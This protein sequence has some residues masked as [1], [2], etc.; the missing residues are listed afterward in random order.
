MPHIIPGTTTTPVR[1]GRTTRRYRDAR[2]ALSSA[3]TGQAAHLTGR[4]DLIA[5]AVTTTAPGAPGVFYPDRA[6]IEIEAGLFEKQPKG[7]RA[8]APADPKA[9]PVG[10]GVFV[11][12]TAHATH[13]RWK[14][15]NGAGAAQREAAIL[16]EEVRIEAAH[17][18]RR[19]ND[20]HWLRHSAKALILADAADSPTA[21]RWAAAHTLALVAGR[22]D[23]GVLTE[24]EAAPVIAA[25]EQHL[26]TGLIAALR[27]VWLR[28]LGLSDD[29]ADG[30]LT[31]GANWCA[32]LDTDPNAPDPA[33]QQGPVTE[34][35]ARAAAHTARAVRTALRRLTAAVGKEDAPAE[36]PVGAYAP[37]SPPSFEDQIAAAGTD[38]DPTSPATGHRAPTPAEVRSAA[39][40]AQRLSHAGLR[41]RAAVTVAS[42][43]PPGRLDMR[44]VLARDAQRAAGAVPTATPWRRTVRKT[45]P[46]PPLRVGIAVDVSVSMRRF[47]GPVASIAW[48]LAQ[49]VRKSGLD[50]AS[51]TVAF[52]GA[53][54]TPI[55][56]PG[57]A[58][59]RVTEFAARVCGHPVLE[60][61]DHLDRALD[62]SRPGAARLLVIVSDGVFGADRRTA[63]D[64]RLTALRGTGCAVLHVSANGQTALPLAGAEH[65]AVGDPSDAGAV[66]GAAAVRA[67]TA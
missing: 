41:T 14:P 4:T 5:S 8:P 12:E 65:V 26:G 3:L 51:T 48:I 54:V 18:R 43:L 34:A 44:A 35:D 49:A 1:R 30:M 60:A 31:A 61:I 40:L 23:A 62:L 55:T 64:R 22:V 47:T 36:G 15:R 63:A 13:S 29:D 58:P 17:V 32:L 56:R 57:Y 27:A 28:A 59:A 21:S 7:R 16:L 9:R 11:H 10:F 67:L 24:S 45:T 37:A 25:V 2:L 66:I 6:A 20:R 46:I 42:T 52:G 33:D 19:P 50:A 53:T 39:L 38:R